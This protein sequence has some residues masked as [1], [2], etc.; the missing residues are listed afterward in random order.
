M[1]QGEW[2]QTG[3]LRMLDDSVAHTYRE[4]RNLKIDEAT[5]EDRTRY[6]NGLVATID[7][8]ISPPDAPLPVG[9]GIAYSQSI[10]LRVRQW[11]PRFGD[12]QRSLGDQLP[13][14]RASLVCQ[15]KSFP[16]QTFPL[17]RS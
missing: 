7:S 12:L 14:L 6:R 15:S 4:G 16:V 17:F 2:P 8:V 11:R 13:A 1:T 5:V 3:A 10:V 9:C